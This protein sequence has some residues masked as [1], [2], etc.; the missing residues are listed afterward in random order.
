[1]N[2]LLK[3][4]GVLSLITFTAS[5]NASLYAQNLCLGSDTT[6]CAGSAITIEVCPN[7]ADTNVV[8]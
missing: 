7:T 5:F 4:F 3:Y 8:F 1:M 2:F 6:I